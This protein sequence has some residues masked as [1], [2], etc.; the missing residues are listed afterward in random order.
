MEDP[1]KSLKLG[2]KALLLLRFSPLGNDCP[3]QNERTVASK[4][5]QTFFFINPPH[6]L[7]VETKFT[8]LGRFVEDEQDCQV[9]L[10]SSEKREI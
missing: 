2:S 3:N 8:N 4:T 6:C 10:A 1:V 5:S 9:F 7:N